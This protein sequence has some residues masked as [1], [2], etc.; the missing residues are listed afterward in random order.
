LGVIANNLVSSATFSNARP[1][2]S[3]VGPAGVVDAPSRASTDC[4]L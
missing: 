2:F 4:C 1:K 3:P